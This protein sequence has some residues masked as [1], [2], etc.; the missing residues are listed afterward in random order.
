MVAGQIFGFIADCLLTK[1]I[2][3]ITLVRKIMHS[4][5]MLVPALGLALLGYVV[6]DWRVSV[7]IMATSYGFRGATYSGHTQVH[8]HKI[9]MPNNCLKMFV[10][11]HYFWSSYFQSPMD[12]TPTFSGPVY[13]LLNGF[14]AVSGLITPLVA[15]ALVADN[16]Q[17]LAGW[18]T[19]FLLSAGVYTF[20]WVLYVA[21]VYVRPLPFDPV[22]KSQSPKTE[23]PFEDESKDSTSA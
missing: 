14:G 8:I 3:G 16:P 18:R 9:T 19:L 4:F 15:T 10:F 12:L 1:D 13:G 17:D 20:A 5:G 6:D 7:A 2:I 22:S 11:F 23:A 21:F